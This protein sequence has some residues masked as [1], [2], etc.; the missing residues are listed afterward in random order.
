VQWKYSRKTNNE[1]KTLLLGLTPLATMSKAEL[2][3]LKTKS[4]ANVGITIVI[5][6]SFIVL[7]WIF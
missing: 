3:R 7:P 4:V 5:K 1:V 6:N 2:Q